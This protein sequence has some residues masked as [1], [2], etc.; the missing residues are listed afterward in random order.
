MLALLS[1]CG[2]G[3]PPDALREGRPFPTLM[4]NSFD[5]GRVSIES[6]R[7]KLVVLN[8]WATWCK[9][10]QRELPSLQRLSD[11][12]DNSRFAVIGLSVDSDADFAQDYLVEHGVAFSSYID[13]HGRVAESRLGIRVYPDTFIISPDG[14]LLKRVVGE[15]D[16]DSP[17]MAQRLEAALRGDMEALADI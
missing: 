17:E 12:L 14:Q 15:R 6:M 4:L 11:R 9:P 16:W 7:G 10:C 13:L 2:Q 3:P 8:I 5:G 1:A